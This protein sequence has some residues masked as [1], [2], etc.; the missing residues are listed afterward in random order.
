L[1]THYL[2]EADRLCDRL[3][4]ID[5]GQI[6]A[7]GQPPELKAEVGG[8]VISLAFSGDEEQALTQRERAVE[9]LRPLSSLT[10]LAQIDGRL[11]ATAANGGRE[12][13]HILRLLDDA[14]IEVMDLS[15]TRPTLDDVFLKYTGERIRGDA[16]VEN[17]RNLTSPF[18]R[19][20]MGAG[21]RRRPR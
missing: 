19:S 6:V 18:G 7:Q 16:P 4:I 5:H 9:L 2:E 20:F 10:S 11:V 14:S 1:T 21:A 3:A 15:L 8:D 17:W 13:P 12:L